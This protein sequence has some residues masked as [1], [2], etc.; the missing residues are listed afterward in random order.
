MIQT[1]GERETSTVTR[2]FFVN[3]GIL[4]DNILQN[5]LIQKKRFDDYQYFHFNVSLQEGNVTQ[6]IAVEV[7]YDETTL[8]TLVC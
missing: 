2:T 1:V 5:G 7:S 6:K 4:L 8:V 3:T